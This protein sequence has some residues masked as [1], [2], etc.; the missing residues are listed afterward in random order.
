VSGPTP[1]TKRLDDGSQRRDD[2]ERRGFFYFEPAKRKPSLYEE[3]TVDTQLSPERHID[4]GWLI[5]FPDGRGTHSLGSTRMRVGD[6]FDFRDPAGLW[7]RPFYQQA[8]QAAREQDAAVASARSEGLFGRMTEEWREFLR[9]SL[10]LPAF[11]E[12]GLWRAA[13]PAARPALSDTLTHAIVLLAA[14]KQRQAQ[15]LVVYAMDLDD[16]IGEC[17]TE[18]ARTRWLDEPAWQPVRRLVESLASKHD[19]VERLIAINLCA[20]PLVGNLLR[21][22]MLLV[23]ASANGDPVTPVIIGNAQREWLWVKGWTVE[24]VRFLVEDAE[25]GEANREVLAEWVAEWNPLAEEAADSVGAELERVP[26]A[27]PVEEVIEQVKAERDELQ[28]ALGVRVAA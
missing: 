16:E 25:H 21:R 7:E 4:F 6:W 3:T 8:A 15:D 10:Q 5:S 13:A 17:S 27:R 12:Q 14:M 28:A 22:E 11:F 24:L 2:G 26:M 9:S 23:P 19:W 20:E 18:A 1:P